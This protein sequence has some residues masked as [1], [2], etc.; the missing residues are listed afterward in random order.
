MKA[1]KEIVDP[2]RLSRRD[3]IE[4]LRKLLKKGEISE[5]KYNKIRPMNVKMSQAHSLPKVHKHFQNISLFRT[6]ICT[7]GSIDYQLE[8]MSQTCCNYSLKKII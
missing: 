3:L 7:V 4:D 8:N 2:L 6:I 5:T 1:T